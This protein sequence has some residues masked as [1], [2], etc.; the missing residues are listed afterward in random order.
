MEQFKNFVVRILNR[1]VAA[2]LRRGKVRVIVVAG[3]IGKTSTTNAIRTVLAQ[4]YRVHMPSTAYNTNKSVHLE[5]FD[6]PFATSTAGW[7]RMVATVLWRSLGKVPY[8]VAVIEI[9]TDHP[10]ELQSF[11]WLKPEIGVLTA[12]APEHMEYFKTIQSVADEELSMADFSERLFFNAN[13]V[14]ANLVPDE[15]K[16]NVTWYGDAT[17]YNATNYR[18]EGLQVR[19]DVR[20]RTKTFAGVEL[21]VLGEHSLDALMAAAAVASACGVAPEDIVA[22]IEKV[23]AVKGRMRRLQG[24]NGVTIIDDS[25]NASP[26]AVCAALDVLATF[27]VPQR[28]A[29]LGSMNEMGGYSEQAHTEVG[30][31]CKPDVLDTVIT[32]GRDANAYLAKS[33]RAKGCTVHEFESPYAAG[34]YISQITKP[35]AVVLFKGSQNG[36]FAE[37]S[38]KSLLADPAD[39]AQLV[40]QSKYWMAVKRRQFKD[41]PADS[42]V[43]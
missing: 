42:L 1:A 5:L 25:Y 35:G 37:E 39:S 28:I 12:I 11:A 32:I 31:Y 19:A 18:V 9:G 23:K 27:D 13:A 30:A 29:V 38:V 15:V 20:V 40:R 36:V 3:S 16:R 6:L 10:G 24:R 14:A 8:E 7:V 33:A 26:Q 4:K 22:G 21:Q 17:D 41:A 34:A 2:Y 43:A